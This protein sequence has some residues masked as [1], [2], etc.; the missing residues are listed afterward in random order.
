M[1]KREIVIILRPDLTE[2]QEEAMIQKIVNKINEKGKV[3]GDINKK[4]K[5]NLAYTVEGFEAGYFVDFQFE[6]QESLVKDID[7]SK[8]NVPCM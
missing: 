8:K 1:K 6:M 7:I 2:E 3:I 5:V 4:G